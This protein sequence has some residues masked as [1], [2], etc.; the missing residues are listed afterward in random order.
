MTGIGLFGVL[1]LV[2]TLWVG[3]QFLTLCVALED[4][5]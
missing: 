2:P 1:P 3:T 4:M 5:P